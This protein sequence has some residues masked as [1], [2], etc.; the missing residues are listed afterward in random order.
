M[1]C[2]IQWI[3]ANGKFTPDQNDAAC[4][5]R[6]NAYTTAQGYRVNTSPWYGCC[7]EHAK[8][9]RDRGMHIWECE[10]LEQAS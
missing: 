4:R 6:V 7:A 5:V 10:Q 9:L 2:E 1:K 8:R 3:D